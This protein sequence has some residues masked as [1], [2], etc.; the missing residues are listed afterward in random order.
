MKIPLTP[1]GIEPATFR[2]V[3]QHINHSTNYTKIML[4]GNLT[5][6]ISGQYFTQA[7]TVYFQISFPVFHSLIFLPFYALLFANLILVHHI[8]PIIYI[9]HK[10]KNAQ[11]FWTSFWNL[12]A[13]IPC[14]ILAVI[15]MYQHKDTT[16]IQVNDEHNPTTYFR[17]KS[18][19]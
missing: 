8:S 13:F 17:D 15:Y 6:R 14:I 18:L 9:K 1:A 2:L 4:V 16:K 7:N 5:R 19:P 11:S 12:I 10:C 3:A